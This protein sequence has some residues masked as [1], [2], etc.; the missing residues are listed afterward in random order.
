MVNV[1]VTEFPLAPTENEQ[2]EVEPVQV[3]SPLQPVKVD[4]VAGVAVR[5][6]ATPAFQLL[7]QVPVF[8]LVHEIPVG[9][10]VTVP[11]PVP[12]VVT[13]TG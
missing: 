3:P 10:E 9:E 11:V 5:L 8:G 4:P 1:A 13:F 2:G 12:A 6:T 7:E